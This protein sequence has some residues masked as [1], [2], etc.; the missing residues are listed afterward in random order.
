MEGTSPADLETRQALQS[1]ADIV[2]PQP[3]AWWPQT[4]GWALLAL[5]VAA[6]IVLA[7]WRWLH[8]RRINRYRREALALLADLEQTG[9]GGQPGSVQAV[10]E[11]LKRVVLAAWPREEVARVSGAAWV[12]FLRDHAG[13][14]MIADEAAALLAD[15]E[16]RAAPPRDRLSEQQF[17]ALIDTARAWI[18]K[19]RVPA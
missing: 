14:A 8:H 4:W 12:K 1:L 16:Y 11:L 15:G 2:L 6:L 19:H 5:V 18:E 13:G 10:A 3:V 7:V 17:R 9:H